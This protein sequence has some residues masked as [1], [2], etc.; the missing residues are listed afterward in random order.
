MVLGNSAWMG[1]T[2]G[3]NLFRLKTNGGGGGRG[4]RDRLLGSGL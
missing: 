4:I 3:A 2:V 1:H